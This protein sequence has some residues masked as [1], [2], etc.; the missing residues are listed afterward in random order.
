LRDCPLGSQYY[1]A[2]NKV[3]VSCPSSNSYYNLN[4]NLCQ[5][6]Q[7]YNSTGKKCS[8]VVTIDPTL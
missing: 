7:N 3:C 5:N 4:T 8:N 1:D 6:C 2:N